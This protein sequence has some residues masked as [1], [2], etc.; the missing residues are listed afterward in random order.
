M[1]ATVSLNRYTPASLL[2]LVSA[3]IIPYGDVFAKLFCCFF[4]LFHQVMTDADI[5]EQV[6]MSCVVGFAHK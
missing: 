3:L 2:I 6:F 4:E 1:P 5:E